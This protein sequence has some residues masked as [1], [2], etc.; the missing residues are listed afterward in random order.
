[1]N[2]TELPAHKNWLQLTHSVNE[3]LD[4]VRR[5]DDIIRVGFFDIRP[6]DREK[7]LASN[8][9]WTLVAS[10]NQ[11]DVDIAIAAPSLI[12]LLTWAKQ[13]EKA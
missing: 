10:D 4:E 2:V 1:M 11:G 7:L 13:L 5:I 12:D 8:D 3:M 6:E 9:V